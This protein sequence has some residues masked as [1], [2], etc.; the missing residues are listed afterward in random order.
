MGPGGCGCVAK[1][2]SRAQLPRLGSLRSGTLLR[3]VAIESRTGG[4]SSRSIRRR[5]SSAPIGSPTS[6]PTIGQRIE[7]L[8]PNGARHLAQFGEGILRQVPVE[9]VN[10]LAASHPL[11]ILAGL[12]NVD[13]HQVLQPT[14]ATQRSY[15]LG[16]MEGVNCVVGK[17]SMT[18]LGSLYNGAEYA[19]VEVTPTGAG[20]PEVKVKDRLAPLIAFGGWPMGQLSGEVLPAVLEVA[21]SFEPVF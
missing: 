7:G 19:R 15:M 11:A 8:Q 3:R 17:T 13:K 20:K 5:G 2:A 14:V 1:F 9:A 21:R 4:P 16:G 10:G 18:L 6:T 12:T